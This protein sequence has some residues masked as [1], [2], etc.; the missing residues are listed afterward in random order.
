LELEGPK[1]LCL[2]ADDDEKVKEKLRTINLS[3]LASGIEVRNGCINFKFSG[4]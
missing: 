4:T 1:G 3:K 2:E